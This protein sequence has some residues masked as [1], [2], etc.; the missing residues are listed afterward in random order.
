VSTSQSYQEQNRASLQRLRQLVERLS[1]DDLTRVLPSGWSVSDTLGHVAFYDRRAA[2]LLE[3]FAT[4]G[5]LASG[6]E[7]V[8]ESGDVDTINAIIPYFTRRI[9]P[10]TMVA[11]AIEAAEAADRA[12]AALPDALLSE[13]ERADVVALSRAEHRD[14]HVEEIEAALA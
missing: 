12:V 2:I 14:E 6:A 10:Q 3:R 5:V 9:P 1:D 11:E 7:G 8:I 4:E 13:V